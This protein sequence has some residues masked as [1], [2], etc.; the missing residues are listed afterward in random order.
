MELWFVFSMVAAVF[1][2]LHLFVQKVGSVR[3][4]NSSL[5]NTYSSALSSVL[6][7]HYLN[8][9]PEPL[10]GMLVVYDHTQTHRSV[11]QV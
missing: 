11:V 4:Y 3:G 10:N 8:F 2:G 7:P 6:V 5:L 1:A 9:E